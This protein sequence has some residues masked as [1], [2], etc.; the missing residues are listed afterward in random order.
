MTFSN[1]HYLLFIRLIFFFYPLLSNAQT[2]AELE[3]KLERTIIINPETPESQ[4]I[5]WED[6]FNL[7]QCIRVNYDSISQRFGLD[8]QETKISLNHWRK[9]DELLLEKTINYLQLNGYPDK[10]I[11]GFASIAPITVFHHISPSAAG[12]KSKLDW[13][14]TFISAYNLGNISY[15]IFSFYLTRLYDELFPE[16]YISTLGQEEEIQDLIQK[17]KNKKN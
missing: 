14:D 6:V 9:V 11:G 1:N 2:C 3:D 12:L 7:D 17:I 4:Q 8:A 13:L 5:F 10:S 15:G 16:R